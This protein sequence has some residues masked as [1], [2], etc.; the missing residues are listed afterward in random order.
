MGDIGLLFVLI[1]IVVVPIM[2]LFRSDD[3]ERFGEV[4]CNRC[5]HT[6][7]TAG[8]WVPFQGM[9]SVCGNC[10]SDNWKVVQGGQ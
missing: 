9:K 6:G 4:K 1:A 2:L 7:K 5:G 3:K 8:K 10:G